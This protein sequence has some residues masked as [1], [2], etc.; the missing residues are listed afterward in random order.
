MSTRT[1]MGMAALCLGIAIAAGLASGL[2]VFA[3]GDGS[4]A[5]AT[6]VRGETYDY[7]TTGVYEYN[8]ERI[9]AEGVGWDIFT[10]FVVVPALVG[11][12]W[13]VGKG[14]LRGRL[15]ALGLLAYTFYQYLM[16]SMTWALGPLFPLWIALYAASLCGIAWV[17]STVSVSGLAARAGDRFPARGMAI[18]AGF[19]GFALLAM[20]T[21]RIAAGLQGD[22]ATAMLLGQTTMVVQAL[23]LGLL[24]PMCAFTAVT[25]WRRRPVGYL[26]SS[27]VAI[28]GVTMSGA[29][30]AMLISAWM[31]EGKPDLL[32][33]VL[34]GGAT[35]G[36]GWLA[37]RIYANV[38]E[39]LAT[40]EAPA[41]ISPV[42][43]S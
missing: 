34:F 12:A 25:A 3:R 4:V 14:S 36:M 6:S 7:V 29:I 35:V 17:A 10:L 8:A 15:L 16:Y 19:M 27:V 38:S 24:V 2:G 43:G 23:D 32:G 21:Q 1:R 18:L 9:V 42:L 13:L 39:E 31:V 37:A 33:F 5:T 28:K 22:Y 20:W 40:A 41:R 26:M 30:V 11:S